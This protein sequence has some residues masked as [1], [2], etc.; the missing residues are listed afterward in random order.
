MAVAT[1]QLAEVRGDEV[2]IW[3]PLATSLAII[4]SLGPRLMPPSDENTAWLVSTA[5]MSL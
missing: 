5:M 3:A 4:S 2:V 1:E